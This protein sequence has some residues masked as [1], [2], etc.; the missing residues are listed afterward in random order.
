M[1]LGSQD[2]I[3]ERKWTRYQKHHKRQCCL[4][5]LWLPFRKS[6]HQIRTRKQLQQH[7][8]RLMSELTLAQEQQDRAAAVAA[9][10]V[11]LRVLQT[12]LQDRVLGETSD[13][14]LMAEPPLLL[15]WALESQPVSH[16]VGHRQ[17][18]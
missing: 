13:A 17:G 4:V 18:P 14:G 15:A 9:V 7:L 3:Q 12:P 2:Q 11:V 16:Q 10:P 8:Q 1:L 5:G 6:P